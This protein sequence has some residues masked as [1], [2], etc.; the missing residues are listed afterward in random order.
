[1]TQNE[2]RVNIDSDRFNVGS[3]FNLRVAK[4]SH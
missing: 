4:D 2:H 3:Y 1:M